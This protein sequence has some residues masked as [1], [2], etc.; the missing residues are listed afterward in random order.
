M[1]DKVFGHLA[2]QAVRSKHRLRISGTR[3]HKT[4][5]VDL[6]CYIDS[7]TITG[8]H[9]AHG[10]CKRCDDR[11]RYSQIIAPYTGAARSGSL[12]VSARGTVSQEEAEDL[13]HKEIWRSERGIVRLPRQHSKATVRK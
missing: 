12:G 10:R 11:R 5:V 8:P 9:R 4:M 6:Q 2:A 13:L 1:V 3:A 7:G